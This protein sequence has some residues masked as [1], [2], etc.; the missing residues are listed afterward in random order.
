MSFSHSAE[1]TSS[2][3][4]E[5]AGNGSLED[6]DTSDLL[7]ML[8]SISDPRKSRGKQHAIGYILAICVVAALAGA[9]NYREIASQA[10]DMPQQLLKEMGAK[11]CWFTL[12]Y[13]YPAKTTIRNVLV[14]IDA[15]ALDA[16]TC[17]WIFAHAVKDSAKN[18]WEIAVDGKVLRGAWT[19]ANDKVTL[20]SAM[21]HDPAVTVAQVRVPDGTN[22]ITQADAILGAMKIPD[23]NSV[24]I[25]MDAAHA[26]TET[27]ESLAGKPDVDYLIKLKGNQPSLQKTVFDKVLPLLGG[28][29]H[30]IMEEHAR[31]QI[32]KWS[33]WVAEAEGTDF[34]H[35]S[36]CAFIRR[37]IFEVSG[38][39]ISKE[40]ALVLTSRNAEKMTASDLNRHTRNHWKI[41][42]KS[43]Y[44]RDTTYQEDHGQAWAGEGPQA[45]SS[46]RNLAIG[47]LRLK[48]VKAIKET[49]QEIGRDRMRAVRYMTT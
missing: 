33:C 37:E 21:I 25:T 26:Q 22:E 11:W 43:H 6:A 29:P 10:K 35:V 18:D 20:F 38:T 47:L 5:T 39:R 46:I 42:N 19:D 23:G 44:I 34:P 31:G 40:H 49:T 16:I 9:K 12:R 45:L 30:D 7:D 48:G 15:A 32:K 17:S 8:A 36:Q 41:E 27:A 24:L 3:G 2:T 14:N 28:T 4:A 1:G 13:A